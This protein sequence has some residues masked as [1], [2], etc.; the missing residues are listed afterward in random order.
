MVKNET[1]LGP[2]AVVTFQTA[3][4]LIDILIILIDILSAANVAA[5]CD[6]F[7][8][9]T[10]LVVFR[11]KAV[12]GYTTFKFHLRGFVGLSVSGP[13]MHTNIVLT[14]ASGIDLILTALGGCVELAFGAF[15]AVTLMT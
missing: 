3:F 2:R 12:Y 11:S 4:T 8:L 5:L 6:P 7:R 1:F 14:K 9:V 10:D 13:N 15:A